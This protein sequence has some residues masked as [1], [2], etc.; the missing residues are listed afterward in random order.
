MSLGYQF[1]AIFWMT[2]YCREGCRMQVI[3]SDHLEFEPPPHVSIPRFTTIKALEEL[4]S[5][6][7]SAITKDSGCPAE[8]AHA[9]MRAKYDLY[10]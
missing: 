1:Y 2:R 7:D 3:R 9:K 10:L 6:V 5:E 4:I 8:E